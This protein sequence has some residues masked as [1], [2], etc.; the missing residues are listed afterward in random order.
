MDYIEENF[1]ACRTFLYLCSFITSTAISILYMISLG[2]IGKIVP[3]VDMLV[4]CFILTIAILILQIISLYFYYSNC[5][6]H[7]TFINL[8]VIYTYLI[9]LIINII[10]TINL[11]YNILSAY[12][13]LETNIVLILVNLVILVIYL[14]YY[15]AL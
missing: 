14:K 2:E 9:L 10:T 4:T 7:E 6:N 5:S 15:V 3:I 8:L 1:T 12:Y 11:P 13:I